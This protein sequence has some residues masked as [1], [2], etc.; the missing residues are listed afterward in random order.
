MIDEKSKVPNPTR[1]ELIDKR[2]RVHV[3]TFVS[4][5]AAAECAKLIYPDQEQDEDRTGQGWDVQVV[6]CD[7]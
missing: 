7:S 4:V 6:G 1:Y 5:L 2:G 3:E